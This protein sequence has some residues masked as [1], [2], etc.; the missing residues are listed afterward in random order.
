MS[1]TDPRSSDLNSGWGYGAVQ[2]DHLFSWKTLTSSLIPQDR[3]IKYKLE[4]WGHN[5]TAE[6]YLLFYK[7]GEKVFQAKDKE[8][9]IKSYKEELT[10]EINPK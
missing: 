9:A 3:I 4:K 8:A 6:Q 1:G 5:P 10:S 2:G 7:F